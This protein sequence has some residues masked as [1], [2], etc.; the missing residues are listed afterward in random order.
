M[1]RTVALPQTDPTV[2]EQV[3]KYS[4]LSQQKAK[5]DSIGCSIHLFVEDEVPFSAIRTIPLHL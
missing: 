4:E 5:N 1:Y 3:W 2:S